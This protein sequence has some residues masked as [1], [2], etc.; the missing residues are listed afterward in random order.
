MTA[1]YYFCVETCKLNSMVQTR[2]MKPWY[3]SKHIHHLLLPNRFR[4]LTKKI[5][6][7]YPNKQP[8]NRI[9]C[10][11]TH[12]VFK[13]CI[14]KPLGTLHHHVLAVNV[15]TDDFL[16]RMKS[17]VGV[18][19][20]TQLV[21]TVFLFVLFGNWN[22]MVKSFPCIKCRSFFHGVIPWW[23]H[24]ARW[25]SVMVKVQWIAEFA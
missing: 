9:Q 13:V 7:G 2:G 10:P 24:I 8:R 16:R 25:T 19:N 17:I 1:F 20:V 15:N 4:C 12:T 11:K 6:F 22:L 18:V 5:A 14:K 21:T 3:C 23:I